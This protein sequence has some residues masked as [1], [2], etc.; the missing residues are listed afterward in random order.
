MMKVYHVYE[1]AYDEPWYP[2]EATSRI[3][4]TFEKAQEYANELVKDALEEGYKFEDD[5][6]W[7][8]ETALFRD[9]DI[10]KCFT[11]NVSDELRIYI[12]EYEVI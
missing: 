2:D 8:G 4:S 1:C 9:N 12:D 5:F 3:Y 7:K 10:Y 11:D 6:A